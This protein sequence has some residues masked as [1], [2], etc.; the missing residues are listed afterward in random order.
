MAV[1]VRKA[2]LG[3]AKERGR[4]FGWHPTQPLGHRVFDR[5]ATACRETLGEPSERRSKADQVE[6]WRVKD[7]G[8][9][10]DLLQALLGQIEDFGERAIRRGST[11]AQALAHARQAQRYGEKVLRGGVM[12]FARD[13][14]APLVLYL[15]Q[16]RSDSGKLLLRALHLGDILMGHDDALDLAP[17]W[18]RDAQLKPARALGA[19]TG[20]LEPE[21]A[22]SSG[23][24]LA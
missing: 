22:P 20:I 1:D 3:D 9:G 11:V 21:P 4:G 23:Y 15:H 18:P 24:D 2:F 10:A 12:G 14:P 6:K 16:T 13:G 5:H 17:L 8:Q 7:V 19:D